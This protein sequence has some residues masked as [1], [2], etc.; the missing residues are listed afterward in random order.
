M[1]Y[2]LERLWIRMRERPLVTCCLVIAVL[3]AVANLFLWRDRRQ[4]GIEH[5]DARRRGQTML[6]ALAGRERIEADRAALGEALAAVDR[7]LAT[8]DSME[9]NLGYFYRLEKVA[10]VRLGRVDQLAA[11]PVPAGSAYQA[12]PVSLQLTGT[13]RQVLGFLRELEAGPRILRVREFRFERTDD[14]TDGD[15]YAQLTVEMLARP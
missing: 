7:H 1:I 12:V 15:L 4:A 5:E 3:A 6:A 14:A 13:Y 11:A 8:E 10:R 2:F 9:A